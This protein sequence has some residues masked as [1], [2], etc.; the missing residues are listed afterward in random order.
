[1]IEGKHTEGK[2]FPSLNDVKDG[3][4]KMILLTNLQDVKVEEKQY[5][6]IPI[7]KL[8]TARLTKTELLSSEEKEIRSLLKK[9]SEENHFKVLLNGQY[10]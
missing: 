2:R 10:L 4:L 9:E 3:L 1:L 8:T 7:L 6:P 5:N